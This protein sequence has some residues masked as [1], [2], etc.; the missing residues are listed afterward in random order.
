M[1]EQQ[2]LPRM[3]AA[4]A[5]GSL[6]LQTRGCD[7]GPI[8]DD[9]HRQ[10]A[11]LPVFGACRAAHDRDHIEVQRFPEAVRVDAVAPRTEAEMMFGELLEVRAKPPS[12]IGVEAPAGEGCGDGPDCGLPLWM[13]A[14]VE[15]HKEQLTLRLTRM[16]CDRALDG[17]EVAVSPHRI[18]DA[19]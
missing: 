16:G 5:Q 8:V 9:Q 17:P 7:F 4:G 2:W 11:C 14:R 3:R 15:L 13:G 19:D 1:G 12:L 10:S 18:G 6:A